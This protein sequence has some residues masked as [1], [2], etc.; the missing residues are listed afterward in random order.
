MSDTMAMRMVLSG[1]N[2]SRSDWPGDLWNPI[3]QARLPERAG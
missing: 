2:I 1:K 3:E